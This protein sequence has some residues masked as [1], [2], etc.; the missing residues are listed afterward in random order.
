MYHSFKPGKKW[1]DTEGKAIQAHGFSVFYSEEDGTYYWYGE[2]KEYTKGGPSNT[3]W[4]WGV[5]AYSSK[6]LYN[7]KDLGL[8]IH[9]DP[10]DLNSPLHPTYCMDRPHIVYCKKTGKYVAWLKI[11]AGVTS[12]FMCVLQADDFMGPYEYLSQNAEGYPTPDYLTSITKIGNV[13]FEGDV[14]EDTEG[15]NLI[16][17]AILDDDERNLFILNWGGF[18]TVARAL[19]SIYDEYSET[20][21]WDEIY[22]KVCDK[23]LISGN[24]QDFTFDDYIADKYPDLVLAHGNCG[25]AG[26][27]TAINGQADALYTFQ[28]DWLKENIK[29][30]HG[31][32]MGLYKLV[33][34]GQ[35]LENEEDRFQFGETNTVYDKEYNDYDFIAEGDSSSIIG[36]YSCGLRGFENGAFGSYGG[37]YSYTKANGEDAG[38]LS[39]LSGGVVPTQYVNPET[40]N[41]EKY[42]P[43]LLDFQLEWAARADWCVNTYENCNHA[44]VVEMEEKDFTAAPGETVSFAATVSD[45]DGDDCTAVWTTEPT[46]CVYSGKDETI[47]N[48]TQDSAEGSFTIPEDAASGDCFCLTLKVQDNADA[49]M[50]RYA[51]VM[52]TVA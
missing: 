42:N 20:D 1:L 44:P 12:Q 51:Q 27:S 26:Y 52:V 7:W 19:L 50:T 32:L 28:A 9:P 24:G 5:R 16:K 31:S 22:Q 41:I 30:D 40:N 18:N 4:H 45:P 21:Q 3:I 34:D 10:D 33:N 13:Q 46:G 36:L 37:R 14:R 8:I 2:N 49:V 29:F 25:Y 15:S 43:F 6:D 11:M 39:T 23:V 47:Y 38:Y 48:W 35:H 17:E